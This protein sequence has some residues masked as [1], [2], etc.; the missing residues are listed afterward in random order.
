MVLA[1]LP[2]LPNWP[3]L[4]TAFLLSLFAAIALTLLV[5]P[6]AKRRPVGT[7]LSWGE[8]MLGAIYAFFTM[9][10]AYGVAPH[11]WLTHA[12]NELR[13]RSDKILHGPGDVV[14]KVVPFTITYENVRDVIASVIYI[15][16]LALQI[17]VWMWWQ[18][19][20]QTKPQP[21]LEASTFGRPLVRRG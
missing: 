18:K 16:F 20:G 12:D 9:F 19:R 11:Q 5:I 1:D 15:L 6:Y 7:P 4:N 14:T 21:E 3:G 17:W 13:W 10:L 2:D 8:A